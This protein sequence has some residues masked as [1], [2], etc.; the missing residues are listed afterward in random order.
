M[1]T[2]AH[3]LCGV[4]SAPN[5]ILANG[6]TSVKPAKAYKNPSCVFSCNQDGPNRCDVA[7]LEFAENVLPVGVPLPLYTLQDEKDKAMQIMGYGKQGQASSFVGKPKKCANAD[8][9]GQ[10]RVAS[11]VVGSTPNNQNGG[12]I[13]YSL[14]NIPGE[15]MAQDGDSGSP[16]VLTKDGQRF[17][18]GVCPLLLFFLPSLS[19][20][21]VPYFDQR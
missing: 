2:A 18:A 4:N 1:V 19:F 5:V 12:V 11:N 13:R 8:G 14:T 16:L 3:C 10:F 21:V 15:G 17:I 6:S 9:D 7:V 20:P